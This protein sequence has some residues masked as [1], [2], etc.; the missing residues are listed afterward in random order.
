[1][2]KSI[3]FDAARLVQNDVLRLQVPMH[4]TFS[5]RRFKGGTNLSCNIDSALWFTPAASTQ[6]RV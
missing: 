2:P 6:D 5:V 4:D 1:M 3:T